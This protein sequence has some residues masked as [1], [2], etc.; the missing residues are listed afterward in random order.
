[1]QLY[2]VHNVEFL[3]FYFGFF[4]QIMRFIILFS[5]IEFAT[6]ILVF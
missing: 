2:R 6:W 3:K 4:I 1:M 5:H